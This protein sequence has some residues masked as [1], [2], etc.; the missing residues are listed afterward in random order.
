M[1]EELRFFLR[2]GLFIVGVLVAYWL[3]SY[4]PAGSALLLFLALALLVFSAWVALQ[5]PR[6]WRDALRVPGRS[7]L[8][9][10]G[11]SMVAVLGL[12]D[13]PRD[14]DAPLEA[15]AE[16]LPPSS[17]WPFL[18]GL[19]V[20]L[21]SLGLVYGPWLALPGIVLGGAAAWGWLTQL[22]AAR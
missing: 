3:L 17:V 6:A 21:V 20:L 5:R 4:E 18:A 11:R 14:D 8:T 16:P 15:G 9:R 10:A 13:G 19:A 1:A 12:P 2:I 22:D 7:P